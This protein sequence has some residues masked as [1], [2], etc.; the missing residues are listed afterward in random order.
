MGTYRPGCD[1]HTPDAHCRIPLT[2]RWPRGRHDMY[3]YMKRYARGI[4]DWLAEPALDALRFR[5]RVPSAISQIELHL[6]Y[7]RLLEEGR[8]LPQL[9]EVGF[10]CYSQADEDGILLFLFSVLGV[11]KR[12]CV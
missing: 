10:K 11:T 8:R 1:A 7:R 5:P 12:L 9:R 4:R 2:L 6:A 3:E